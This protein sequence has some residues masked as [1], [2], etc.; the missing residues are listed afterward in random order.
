MSFFTVSSKTMKDYLR[1]KKI[2]TSILAIIILLSPFMSNDVHADSE[3]FESNNNYYVTTSPVIFNYKNLR[4][5][6]D[7]LVTNG[8]MAVA[9]T[10]FFDCF[11]SYTYDWNSET[12]CVTITDGSNTYTIYCGTK[13]VI[14]NGSKIQAPTISM[15][16]NDKIYASLKVMSDALNLKTLYDEVS[17]AILIA[18]DS[19]FFNEFYT[20]DDVYWLSRIV[21]SEAGFES[22]E[23][24]VAVAN[25]VLNR[26]KHPEFPNTVYGV[27]FDKAGGVQFTPVAAGTIYNEPSEQAILAAR[28]ALNGYNNISSCLFF[29]N[30]R[31]A[32]SF[33]IAK[34]CSFFGSI[35]NHDFYF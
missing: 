13:Y 18:N 17:D 28:A 20:F 10:D 33:W 7:K 15:I 19:F 25:V 24:M 30:P 9:V 5:K 35:G 14:K 22:Y 32:K 4:F 11:G 2:L 8:Y 31:L 21:Y 12:R 26:V 6:N 16:Y 1:L 29:F 23:G 27:I 34:A 3:L